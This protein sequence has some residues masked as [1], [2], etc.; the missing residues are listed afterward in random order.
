MPLIG[1]IFCGRH[2]IMWTYFV[3]IYAM[4]VEYHSS[5]PEINNIPSER[6]RVSIGSFIHDIAGMEV[7]V[8]ELVVFL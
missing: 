1:E 6:G 3:R 2:R 7:T 8:T 5:E 4:T